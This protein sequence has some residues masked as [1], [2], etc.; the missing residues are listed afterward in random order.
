[1]FNNIYANSCFV[2]YFRTKVY[3]TKIK[4]TKNNYIRF[5]T[6]FIKSPENVF[7]NEKKNVNLKIELMSIV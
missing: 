1:M 6:I 5:Y 2:N 4:A 7:Y 3:G